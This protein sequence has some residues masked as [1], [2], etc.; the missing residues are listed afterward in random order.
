MPDKKITVAMLGA[1]MHYAVPR[2]LHN[3]GLLDRLY[4][5][6]YAGNKPTLMAGLRLLQ[7]IGG[8]RTAAKWLG[9][10]HSELPP[11]LVTSFEGLGIRFALERRR[12]H[13]CD[14]LEALFV[15]TNRRFAERI[16]RRGLGDAHAVWGFCSASLEIFRIA[17]SEGRFCIL[18]QAT[19]PR[20]LMARLLNKVAEDWPCW[21]AGFEQPRHASV[22]GQREV[23]EWSLADLI[24]APSDFVADG[25]IECGV[26]ANKIQIIPYGVS[27]DMF[28]PPSEPRVADGPL[29]ILFVGEVGLRK[30]TPYLLE[31]LREL[32]PKKVRARFA[33]SV[34]LDAKQLDR[35]RDVVEFMGAVPRTQMPNLY[36]WAQVFV[37]PSVVE[38]SATASYEALMSGIPVVATHNTGTIVRNGIEGWIVPVRDAD[39]ISDALKCYLGNPE[40]L[41]NHAEA[42]VASRHRVDL[43]RYSSELLNTLEKVL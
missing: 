19:L 10:Q 38:G 39:A 14:A 1:R 24:V 18:E 36:Q 29:R 8:G 26:A 33:G 27:T 30:G 4:T 13:G 16:I 2:I 42:A 35:Y 28:P 41:A 11:D 3:A 37:L 9:R 31:A 17:K 6:S 21:Q 20:L 15:N 43:S 5:D 22:I 23:E 40:L 7:K 34:L 25:L 32:G 12:T